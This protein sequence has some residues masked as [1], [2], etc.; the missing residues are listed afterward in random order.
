MAYTDL[1]KEIGTATLETGETVCASTVRRLA[2]DADLIPM[3]LG[4]HGEILDVGRLNRLVTTAIW[5]ALVVRDRHCTFPG[6]RRPP[7]ACD[8]HHITHW[9]D[10]GNTG[11]SNL[12]LLCRTHHTMIHNS[13]WQIRLNPIDKRPEFIPPQSL[14]FAQRPIRERRPR[15]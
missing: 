3:V 13:P 9:I 12:A 7:I 11:L 8:A 1:V 6:C 4:S 5:I 15:I 14:D 2:C 10:G